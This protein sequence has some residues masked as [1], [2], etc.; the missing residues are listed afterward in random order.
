M[1]MGSVPGDGRWGSSESEVS[2]G[3]QENQA[4]IEIGDVH[5]NDGAREAGQTR[6]VDVLAFTRQ[7]HSTQLCG[8]SKCPRSQWCP[9]SFLLVIEG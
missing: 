8:G 6:A 5:R 3:L 1:E 2:V 7:R 9:R 4:Y